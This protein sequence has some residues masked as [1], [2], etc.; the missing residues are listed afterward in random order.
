LKQDSRQN[1]AIAPK[2]YNIYYCKCVNKA[3][4]SFV[5]IVASDFQNTDYMNCGLVV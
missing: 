2:F 4:E 5:E 1:R 3:T